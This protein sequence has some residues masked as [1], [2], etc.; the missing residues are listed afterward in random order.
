M[1]APSAGA[2][3]RL[4]RARG[5]RLFEGGAYDLNLVVLRTVPGD[6]DA[7]DDWL[8]V[9]YRDTAQGP[10]VL[11]ALE[12][13][14]DPGKLALEQGRN[15]EGVAIIQEGQHRGAYTFGRH[16]GKYRCLVPRRPIPCWRDANRDA[17]RDLGTNPS[18]SAL[19]QIHAG[20]KSKTQPVGLWS[21]GCVA[22][23][24]D[25][26]EQ[27]LDLCDKQVAAGHGDVFS[28]TVIDRPA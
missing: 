1:E 12:C 21:E 8:C 19:L 27:L 6:V 28:L 20:P 10:W 26:L 7:W 15:P 11:V 17:V 4:M 18:N 3:V 24:M 9:L 14:A 16:K 22:L 2:L 13:T 23:P 5:F 25:G